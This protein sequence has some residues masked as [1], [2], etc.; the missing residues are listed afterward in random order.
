MQG[1]YLEQLAKHYLQI[2]PLWADQLGA[3]W[4]WRDWPDRNGRPDTGI[5]LVAEI[6]GGGL[7]AV[8]AKFFAHDHRMQKGDL[9]S[10]FEAIGK[11]P[12]TEGLV[13]DTT[14]T[15]WSINAQEALKN[16]SKPVRKVSLDELRHSA[17]DWSSYELLKPEV[18]PDRH[19]RKTLRAHQ[20]AAIRSVMDALAD[21]GADR[22]K[23]IMACG[24]GKTFTALKLAERWTVERSGGAATVLFM[25]PSLALLQQTLDEWSRERDPEL[26][27]RAF[28]V[29]SDTNI[30]R[31]KNDD[32]TSVMIEDLG[33]PATT[34][35]KRLAQLLGDT[36]EQH[37]GM[38]VVF[39]T[40]QSIDAVAEAQRLRGDTFDLVICDEAHRTTGVTL[41]NEDE[42]HFVKIHDDAVIPAM[43][44]VYMTA[45]PRI[46]A[47]EV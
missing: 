8:Q 20:H 40:Y 11:E 19:E 4:L 29:G 43:K 9:D 14:S 10:F 28:A 18:A 3:V 16:R 12:F 31:R 32:L 22:G 21:G 13:I 7:L 5:D 1:N 35:G 42:S 37:D 44:R 26:G 46:F 6:Q 45:T 34:D 39:S 25:V 27:F 38:T 47:P 15:E 41:A 30:G 23:L 2:E 36:S 33:A 17:I 24:T